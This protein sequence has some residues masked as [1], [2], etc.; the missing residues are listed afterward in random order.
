MPSWFTAPFF[1]C[2]LNVSPLQ[3]LLLPLYS[4]LF[5]AT[6]LLL[7]PLSTPSN[8]PSSPLLQSHSSS[9]TLAS[10]SY[11]VWGGEYQMR[12]AGERN[13]D[14]SLFFNI[15]IKKLETRR[16]WHMLCCRWVAGRVAIRSAA[17]LSDSTTLMPTSFLNS[18][19]RLM[20]VFSS[21]GCCS[22]GWFTVIRPPGTHR[23][24]LPIIH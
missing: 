2:I 20:G 9:W 10:I 13:K 16:E 14:F 12:G 17:G 3:S 19:Y 22:C 4:A 8:P 15:K 5:L 24:T 21:L 1:C 7:V 11:K 23:L 6:S 18:N